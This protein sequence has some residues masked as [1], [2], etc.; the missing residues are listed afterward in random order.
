MV[1]RADV[2]RNSRVKSEFSDDPSI[3]RS[4]PHP[5]LPAS[6]THHSHLTTK[7]SR[8]LERDPLRLTLCPNTLAD[9]K[10]LQKW[11]EMDSRGKPSGRRGRRV[12]VTPPPHPAQ[13]APTPPETYLVP[14]QD[15]EGGHDLVCC[16]CVGRLPR[17]K[18]NE[19]LERHYTQAVGI[20]DAHDTGKFCL[21]LER[22]TNPRPVSLSAAGCRECLIRTYAPGGSELPEA[23]GGGGHS[24][25]WGL[26]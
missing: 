5:T 2:Q 26:S 17:H 20:H 15:L 9:P 14:S 19:G 24:G 3:T 6:T 8:S 11:G 10:T 22:R 7:G 21:S 12:Q 23:A 4:R 16:V 25:P 1:V 13:T 18:V